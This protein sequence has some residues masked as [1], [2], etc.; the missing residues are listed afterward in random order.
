MKKC[1]HCGELKSL[2][3]FY[4]DGAARDGHRPECKVCTAARRKRW[5][6]QNREREIERVRRW[7]RANPER[8]RATAEAAKASGRKKQTDRR[9]YLKRKY[10]VTPEWYDQTLEA[11][12]GGCAICGR[13]PRDDISLHVDH[14]HTTGKLR[15]LLCFP[16]NNLLGDVADDAARLRS[17]AEYLERHDPEVIELR[18]LAKARARELVPAAPP[19]F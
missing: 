14:D 8:V 11:Q 2:D 1:K 3:E 19:L 12:G 13:P 10:G 17:A 16:C 15:K 7:A 5:Y 9:S 18:D 4:G 6:D